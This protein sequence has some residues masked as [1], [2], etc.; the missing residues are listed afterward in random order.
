MHRAL[1]IF[2]YFSPRFIL[3]EYKEFY[4]FAMPRVLC[5]VCVCVGVPYVFVSLNFLSRFVGKVAGILCSE[6]HRNIVFLI[7]HYP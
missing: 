2:T 5:G 4:K 3:T 7:L 1:C 6:S